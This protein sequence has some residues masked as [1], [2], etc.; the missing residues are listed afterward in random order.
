MSKIGTVTITDDYGN[1]IR[2]IEMTDMV[3]SVFSDHRLCSVARTEENTFVLVV[4]N[5]EST[6]RHP[7]CQMHL[8]EESMLAIVNAVFLYYMH[9]D[10]DIN[11][12]MKS[13]VD[14]DTINFEY[15]DEV[16]IENN[17]N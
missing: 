17:K 6:G 11:E 16:T 7:R 12:K 4:E 15:I 2:K 5:P 8:S 13:I 1:V 10:I 3:R 14:S 9:H